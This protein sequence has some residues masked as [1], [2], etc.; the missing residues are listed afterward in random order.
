LHCN[1]HKLTRI[2][3]LVLAVLGTVTLALTLAP[4]SAVLASNRLIPIYSVGQ[5][6]DTVSLTF[7][8]AWGA[9]KTRQ[10]LDC[11]DKLGV[12]CTFFLVSIWVDKYPNLVK[13]IDNRGHEIGTHSCTHGDM[14]KM[15]KQQITQ[16]LKDSCKAI[17][18]ITGKQVKLFRPPFGA[19]NNTL[20][21]I[22][23]ELGL[24]TIQWSVD[25]LDWKGIKAGQIAINIQKSSGGDII[26]CHNN[27]DHIVDAIPLIYQAL[28]VKN[29]SI[30]PVGQLIYWQDYHIDH[31]GKQHTNCNNQ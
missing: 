18:D 30:V 22:A 11:L 21:E 17:T 4:S 25:S 8:A 27:S 3:A 20:I 2:F 24:T 9:D 7:D 15:S 26:L 10:I 28:T 14:T 23:T 16:E 29:L 6:M 13:E 12:K 5:R 1:Y 31:T 19:Y